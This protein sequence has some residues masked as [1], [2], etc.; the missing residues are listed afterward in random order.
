MNEDGDGDDDDGGVNP[1]DDA[2]GVVDGAG[3]WVVRRLTQPTV[4]ATPEAVL[5]TR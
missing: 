2:V 4:C 3:D 1:A 5:A